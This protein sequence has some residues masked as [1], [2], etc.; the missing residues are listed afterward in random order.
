MRTDVMQMPSPSDAFKNRG[1]HW[2]TE[3]ELKIDVHLLDFVEKKRER[4][5]QSEQLDDPKQD[6]KWAVR[7]AGR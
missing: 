2:K 6:E 1:K 7:T 3:I 4:Q 5:S